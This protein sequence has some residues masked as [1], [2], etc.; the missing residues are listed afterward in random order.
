MSYKI[1]KC[2]E[3]DAC[4]LARLN[5]NEMGYDYSAEKTEA[6]LKN[7]LCKDYEC[8]FVAVADEKLV[9]YIHISEYEL[10]YFPKMVN[11]LGIAVDSDYK[12][13]GIGRALIQEAEQWARAH[14]AY[15]M[16]LASGEARIYAHAF[17]E[18]CGFCAKGAQKKFRKML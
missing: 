17:Y 7:V 1:R 15:E 12:R 3:S 10:L 18:K 6:N 9:G 2:E 8:I 5:K 13:K 16:R 14:E 11:I 4:S